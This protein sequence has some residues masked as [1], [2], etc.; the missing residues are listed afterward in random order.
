MYVYQRLLTMGA[1]G[2]QAECSHGG[3]EPF[4]PPPAD[5]KPVKSLAELRVD[6]EV[7]NTRHGTFLCKWF[8][9]KSDHK[10]LGFETRMQEQN[11]DP[12][13]IYLYDYKTI[14]GRQLPH[15]FQVWYQDRRYG[16]FTVTSYQLGTAS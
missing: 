15:A 9:S 2:F 12:C 5:G 1:E 13:E 10:L 14:Q 16:N 3:I 6:C 8:F 7:L 4:Y 11:E